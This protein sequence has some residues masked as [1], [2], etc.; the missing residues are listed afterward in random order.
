M[1]Q[2]VRRID[3]RGQRFGAGTSVV[4]LL[5]AFAL[6]S[7]LLVA[8]VGVTLAVSSALGTRYFLLSRP[9]PLVRRVLGIGPPSDPEPELGPR[10]SQA[11]GATGLLLGAVLLAVGADPVGWGIVGIVAAL[12]FVLASTGFC[13]GCRLYGLNWW[14][15]AQFDRLIGVS[16]ADR[17]RLERPPGV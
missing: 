9:W 14:L 2:P 12:Q 13:L 5:L 4:L 15:P 1:T 3:P 8:V 10:F 7:P 17:I 11:M 16:R 6:R